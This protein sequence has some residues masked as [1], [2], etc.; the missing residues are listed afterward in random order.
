M[1]ANLPQVLLQL[2]QGLH[3]G[4]PRYLEHGVQVGVVPA[5][6]QR[7]Q[8]AELIV[9]Q[10]P[11]LVLIIL[12]EEGLGLLVAKN[13]PE[14]CQCL[15]E[16][17]DIDGA[18]VGLIEVPEG[19]LGSFTLILLRDSLLPDLFKKSDFQLS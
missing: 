8:T 11:A 4:L 5:T 1:L 17:P 19:L 3:R 6:H 14:L 15:C 18:S 12:V 10:L 7:Y 16:L 13:T 9:A 2:L